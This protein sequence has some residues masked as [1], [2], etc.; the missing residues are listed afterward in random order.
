MP[1]PRF[2][3]PFTLGAQLDARAAHRDFEGR[4]AVRSGGHSWS[5]REFRDE[6]VRYAH[7][8]LRRLGACDD[9]RPGYVAMLLENHPELLAL[10]AGCGYAGLSLFGVNSGLRGDALAGVIDQSRARLLV[11][12][13]RFAP[14]VSRSEPGKRK[15]TD[16]PRGRAKRGI[17]YGLPVPTA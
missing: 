16:Y 1:P 8:L 9:T 15:S 7:F 17:R 12:D 4:T 5:Y 11:V 6:A 3:A 14:E 2:E 10:Y 13:E